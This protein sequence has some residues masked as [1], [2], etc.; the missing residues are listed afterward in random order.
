VAA[1]A[2]DDVFVDRYGGVVVRSSVEIERREDGSYSV[3]WDDGTT[4][5]VPRLLPQRIT[6]FR[7]GSV[8]HRAAV[9]PEKLLEEFKQ[10]PEQL[11]TAILREH[12]GPL[13]SQELTTAAIAA[14]I[15]GPMVRAA[16]PKVRQ[17]WVRHPNI[18]PSGNPPTFA[19]IEAT[20]VSSEQLSTL[21]TMELLGKLSEKPGDE[22][23]RNTI[24]FRLREEPG[25][26]VELAAAALKIV[27]WPTP[28][29]VAELMRGPLAAGAELA[30]LGDEL[31][32]KTVQGAVA[33]RRRDL[34]WLLATDSR[35]A[36]PVARLSEVLRTD[37][38]VDAVL[39]RLLG[40]LQDDLLGSDT[41][42]EARIAAHIG[43]V[44]ARVGPVV[45]TPE[46]LAA[47]FGLMQLSP[48]TTLTEAVLQLLPGLEH[49]VI[50]GAAELDDPSAILAAA[51]AVPLIPGSGR[52]TLLEVAAEAGLDG[53]TAGKTWEGV[54][55][56]HLVRMLEAGEL[57]AV[58][59]RE[60]VGSAV[61][62]PLAER[63]VSD[64]TDRR[65]LAGILAWPA[66]LLDR[67]DPKV[68]AGAL[69]AVGA[70]DPT[71]RRLLAAL[72]PR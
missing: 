1:V 18:R 66:E 48:G 43:T 49:R 33:E 8:K 64:A 20:T 5:E 65:G 11:F 13:R 23:A 22:Q 21:P 36:G 29:E 45:S 67:I 15:D 72:T 38:E 6:R 39:A 24:R 58:L 31:L 7:R 62:A 32:Q 26:A 27:P 34:I 63:A 2:S 69:V 19:W 47:L 42:S 50:A 68:L 53:L 54:E 40:R 25:L 4:S 3:L 35:P 52:A 57:A 10:A 14:G 17:G 55:I 61:V 41:A 16:W 37:P 70:H 46:P 30:P 59:G 51:A 28:P 12:T 44:V 56:R 60:D 71:V 9:E